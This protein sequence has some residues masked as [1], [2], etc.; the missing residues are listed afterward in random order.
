MGET[1]APLSV[2]VP[3]APW[4]NG[5]AAEAVVLAALGAAEAQVVVAVHPVVLGVAADQGVPRVSG[6]DSEG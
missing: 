4:A 1:N 5:E 2:V 3:A 6:E